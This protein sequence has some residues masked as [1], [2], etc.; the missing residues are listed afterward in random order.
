MATLMIRHRVADYEAWK[1]GYDE[2]DW[3]R[4][5]HGILYASVHR[6]ATDPNVVMAVHRF[7]DMSGANEFADAVRPLMEQIGVEGQPEV[8]IGEDV[9]RVSYS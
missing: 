1:R 7:E 3:L 8:W 4:K 5:Q 2:A 9:E 6:D